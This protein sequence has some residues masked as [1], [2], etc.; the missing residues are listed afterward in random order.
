[1]GHIVEQAPA[2]LLAGTTPEHGH[3][4]QT[5]GEMDQRREERG[6][7]DAETSVDI[8]EER[9]GRTWQTAQPHLQPPWEAAQVVLQHWRER[10][11]VPS[12]S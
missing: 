12:S 3:T 5:E 1:M 10:K 6:R 9:H 8:A 4:E 11:D 2:F 7:M